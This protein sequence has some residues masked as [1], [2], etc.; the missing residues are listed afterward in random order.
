MISQ[1]RLKPFE[2]G[3]QAF[4]RF[5]EQSG[6]GG[7]VLQKLENEVASLPFVLPR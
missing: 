5:V 7:D 4:R 3:G 1:E 2:V 6:L